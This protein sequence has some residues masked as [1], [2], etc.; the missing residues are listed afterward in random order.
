[1]THQE[2]GNVNVLN[3]SLVN[4]LKFRDLMLILLNINEAF[5]SA[6]GY[7]ISCTCFGYKY[8]CKISSRSV[9][10]LFAKALQSDKRSLGAENSKL[11]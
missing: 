8:T 4:E 3:N 10:W 6:D 2:E 11:D 7:L 9:G 1:M 5:A